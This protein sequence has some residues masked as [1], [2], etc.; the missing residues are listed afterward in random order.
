MFW[1]FLGFW[2]LLEG[3]GNLMIFG[4]FKDLNIFDLNP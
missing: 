2:G 3:F 4:G 1:K